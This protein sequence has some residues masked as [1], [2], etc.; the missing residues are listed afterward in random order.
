MTGFRTCRRGVSLRNESTIACTTILG[1]NRAR[2]FTVAA[3]TFVSSL[4]RDEGEMLDHG[5]ERECRNEGQRANEDD[6]TDQEPDKER[7]VSRKRSAARRDDLL[8]GQRAGDRQDGDSEPVAPE[9]HRKSERRV[10]EGCVRR[11]SCERAAVV[12]RGRRECV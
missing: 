10:V 2:A 9:Q 5:S 7:G 6:D 12:V 11:D 4:R 3:M 1:S 8:A